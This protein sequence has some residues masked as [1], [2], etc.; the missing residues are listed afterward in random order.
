MNQYQAMRE[1]Q[2]KAFNDIPVWFAFGIDQF[3]KKLSE[4]GLTMEQAKEEIVNIGAGG[5]C[6]KADYILYKQFCDNT[7]KEMKEALQRFDFAVD[8]FKYEMANHEFCITNDY[9]DV[10]AAIGLTE[11]EI[12]GSTRLLEALKEATRL[13]KQGQQEMEQREEKERMEA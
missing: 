1:K 6:K 9:A 8:A 2:Q 3:E 7:D 10:V 4:L 13:Y 12:L 11:D 5:Y